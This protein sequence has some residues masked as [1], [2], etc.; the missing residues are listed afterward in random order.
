[1]H[2]SNVGKMKIVWVHAHHK[3]L[4]NATF[5]FNVAPTHNRLLE[6]GHESILVTDVEEAIRIHPDI[7]VCMSA[8]DANTIAK[9]PTLIHGTKT[10]VFQ[11]DGPICSYEAYE[12][13]DAIVL[14]STYLETRV[15]PQFYGKTT[16]IPDSIEFSRSRFSPKKRSSGKLKLVWIGAGGNF[17][18]AV[19]VISMLATR[20]FDITLISDLPHNDK[21]ALPILKGNL[22]PEVKVVEWNKDTYADELNKCDVGIAPYPENLIVPDTM[23]FNNFYYKDNNRLVTMQAVGLPVICSPLPSYLAYIEHCRTGLIANSMTDWIHCVNLLDTNA[24]A[25]NNIASEGHFKA[26]MY[27]DRKRVVGMWLLLFESVMNSNVVR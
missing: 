7:I 26:W 12:A 21:N 9:V 25:Y 5:R 10:I 16:Y 22:H 14:D 4:N 17:F 18:F 19:D 8:N 6:L 20:Q 24:E 3:N 15:P 27:A 13:V 1:M 2:L 23:S 11:S